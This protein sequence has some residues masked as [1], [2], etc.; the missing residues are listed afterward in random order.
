MSGSYFI[1]Q[2]SKFLLNN[3]T[4]ATLGQGH[5]KV[6]QYIFPDECFLCPNIYG[7]AQTAEVIAVAAADPNAAETNWKH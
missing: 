1:L 2:T 7:L 6:I 3:A 5:W 4:A